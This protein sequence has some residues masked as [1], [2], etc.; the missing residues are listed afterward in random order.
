MLCTIARALL[1]GPRLR[2]GLRMQLPFWHWME[3]AT[4]YFT[5]VLTVKTVMFCKIT[6]SL[7]WYRSSYPYWNSACPES[8][9]I[10]PLMILWMNTYWDCNTGMGANDLNK[11]S[12]QWIIVAVIV[13][14]I[15]TIIII[16]ISVRQIL[17]IP[18][19]E[20]LSIYVSLLPATL[21]KLTMNTV[22]NG[23]GK[24]SIWRNYIHFCKYL[25]EVICSVFNSLDANMRCSVRFLFETI[26][27]RMNRLRIYAIWWF[28]LTWCIIDGALLILFCFYVYSLFTSCTNLIINNNC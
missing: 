5:R 13:I 24:P 8:T 23:C 20:V 10:R 26:M 18:A 27:I 15:I 6:R 9:S 1:W 3:L 2:I 17:T 11:Q 14:T 22:N 12:W 21:N 28:F 19:K 16:I 7:L 4:I 25:Y